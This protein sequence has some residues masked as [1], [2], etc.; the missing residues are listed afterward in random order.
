VSERF[1]RAGA[2]CRNPERSEGSHQKISWSGPHP[3]ARM[4]QGWCHRRD[5]NLRR[6]A[7]VSERFLRAGACCRN[8]ER[9]EG[10]HRKISWRGPHLKARMNQ[11]WCHRRDSNLRCLAG[12]SERFLRAGACCRNP[13]RAKRVEGPQG[14]CHRRDSNLR[15]LAGVSERF[16]RAGACCRNPERAKRVEGSRA[17]AIEG[18]R[19]PTPLRVHGPEPCASAN[20]ATM[21]KVTGDDSCEPSSGKNYHRLF[22]RAGVACQSIRSTTESRR[23]GGFTFLFSLCLRDSVVRTIPPASHSS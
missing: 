5:S 16:L 21:A 3:K 9:S 11:G 17:G 14:W 4:T 18:T 13:E 7:G 10:S 1:L 19:T 2:C 6:L 23:H 12:V 8:P 22:Y 15:R 20:S